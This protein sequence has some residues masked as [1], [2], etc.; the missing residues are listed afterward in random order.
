MMESYRGM[1]SIVGNNTGMYR[2]YNH[3][4]IIYIMIIPS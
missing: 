3:G 4:Y 1:G 2:V